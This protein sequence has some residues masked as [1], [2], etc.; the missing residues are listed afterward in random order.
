MNP[1]SGRFWTMDSYEGSTSDPKT[2]HKYTYVN[3][4]PVDS[5]DPSGHIGV[6]SIIGEVNAVSW[7]AVFTVWQYK[8]VITAANLILK[9]LDVGLTFGD[10]EYRDVSLSTGHNPFLSLASLALDARIAFRYAPTVAEAA[11]V[12]Q[13][14]A[15]A[16]NRVVI[17]NAGVSIPEKQIVNFTRWAA[18][19]T[20]VQEQEVLYRVHSMEGVPGNWWTRNRPV[21]AIQ[22]RI[23]AALR[24]EWNEAKELS[25]MIVPKG[26]GLQAWEGSAAYQGGS[27]IGGGNQ[28][29]IPNVPKQ[30]VTTLPFR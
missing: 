12:S 6:G 19:P 17:A 4:S 1:S 8:K 25:T 2:L 16:A 14:T 20:V 22:F 30:W 15:S 26:Y 29:F 27:Y 23:D 24:P 28:L 18:N 5:V 11:Y 13:R 21:S 9:A 7:R 10:T 3:N